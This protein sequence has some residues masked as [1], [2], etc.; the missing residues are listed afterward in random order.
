MLETPTQAL[1]PVPRTVSSG[2]FPR[3]QHPH[4]WRG[5]QTGRATV[6]CV[7]VRP[8]SRG[9]GPHCT[10]LHQARAHPHS[11]RRGGADMVPTLQMGRR[12]W[13]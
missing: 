2:E 5:Q 3:T 8:S 11:A 1:G 10:V 12:G 7:T 4:R 9:P 6:R 13:A